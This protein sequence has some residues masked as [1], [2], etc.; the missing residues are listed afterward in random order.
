MKEKQRCPIDL[1]CRVET[2][3]REEVRRL[4]MEWDAFWSDRS[5][6]VMAYQRKRIIRMMVDAGPNVPQVAEMIGKARASVYELY[7]DDVHRRAV[8]RRREKAKY[9]LRKQYG[10]KPME[11]DGSRAFALAK[12]F[13]RSYCCTWEELW[14][15]RGKSQWLTKQRAAVRYLHAAGVS[16]NAISRMAGRRLQTIMAMLSPEYQE[17]V[18][19]YCRNHRAAPTMDTPS[20]MRVSSAAPKNKILPG[21]GQARREQWLARVQSMQTTEAT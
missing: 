3:A 5:I 16:K 4:G 13:C 8:Q 10:R 21:S 20:S 6:G 15:F 7:D 11:D 14:E 17:R 19:Q 12:E 9:K 1:A 18:R 2:M